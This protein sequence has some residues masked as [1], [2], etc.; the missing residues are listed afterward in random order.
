[1]SVHMI[2]AVLR[3]VLNDEYR[4]F[5]PKGTMAHVVDQL[6]EGKIVAGHARLRS[7]RSDSS[8]IGVILAEAHHDEPW[9]CLAAQ[10][11]IVFSDER[12]NIVGIADTSR[13]F[14]NAV[15]RAHMANEPGHAPFH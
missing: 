2:G 12:L 7:E 9:H 11:M 6:A 3:I 10:E 8:S 4:C 1:M 5:A 15:C 13:A 14:R